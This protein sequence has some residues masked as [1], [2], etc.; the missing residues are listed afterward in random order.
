MSLRSLSQQPSDIYVKYNRLQLPIELV[1]KDPSPARGT[2][3][4]GH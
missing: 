3:E 2:V 4:P 1:A